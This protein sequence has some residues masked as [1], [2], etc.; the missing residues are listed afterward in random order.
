MNLMN[1]APRGLE[2]LCSFH[3]GFFGIPHVF[4]GGA[5]GQKRFLRVERRH[6]QACTQTDPNLKRDPSTKTI[7][8]QS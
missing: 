4:G 5:Q 3:G 1:M 8:L 6:R 2:D 7:H